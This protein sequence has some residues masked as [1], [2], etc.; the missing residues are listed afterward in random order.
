[1]PHPQSERQQRNQG[2][3]RN[4]QSTAKGE[5]PEQV[6][7]LGA[8]KAAIWLNVSGDGK[9]ERTYRT[10]TLSR[11]FQQDGEWVEQK[12]SLYPNDVPAVNQVLGEVMRRLFA[13]QTD[14]G[15][16]VPI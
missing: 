4:R 8:I 1:M 6:V 2:G 12:I 5:P 13:L 14:T 16:E 3:G 15:E 11:S 9:D 7:R 10:V